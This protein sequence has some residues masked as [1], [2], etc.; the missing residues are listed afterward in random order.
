MSKKNRIKREK[1][2]EKKLRQVRGPRK[3][4]TVTF[5]DPDKRLIWLRNT[6]RDMP[7]SMKAIVG[8]C[9]PPEKVTPVMLVDPKRELSVGVEDAW[10]MSVHE[11][12]F[13]M[14]APGASEK[15][16]FTAV[17]LAKQKVASSATPSRPSSSLGN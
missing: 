12:V 2:K 6:V 16:A 8:E 14:M 11:G 4:R 3:R 17:T 5:A 9:G 7:P 15:V 10:P 13:V 1:S